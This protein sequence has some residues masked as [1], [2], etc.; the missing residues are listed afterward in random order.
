VN[1][2][3]EQIVVID[4]ADG[5]SVYSF[6]GFMREWNPTHFLTMAVFPT[7]AAE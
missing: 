2:A 3:Q 4:P 6:D 1:R 5:L 7:P